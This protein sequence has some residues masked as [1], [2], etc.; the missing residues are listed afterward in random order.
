MD[1]NILTS[2]EFIVFSIAIVILMIF[3][4]LSYKHKIFI[5]IIG[6]VGVLYGLF[7]IAWRIGFSIPTN[8]SVG[9][10]F[11]IILLITEIVG[12]IQSI[13]FKVFLSTNKRA[14]PKKDTKFDE[15]PS[16]DVIIST[17]NEPLYILSRTIIST[18]K[19]DYPHDKLNV[20]VGDDGSRKD[21]EDFC[22]KVGAHYV[23]REEHAHAKAGNI[24][25]V[26]NHSSG[27]YILL[28]DADM[29][30]KKSIV[31]D[32]IYYFEDSRTGFVQSPQV[33]YNSDVYQNN[34]RVGDS[35]PNEQDFFM[36]DIL[37]KRAAYNAVL[38]VGSNAIFKRKAI[39]DIGGIPTK[40]ITEDMATGMLIQAK[41]YMSYFVNKPLALGLSVETIGDLIKQRDRWLRG[42]IQVSKKYHPLKI[43]GLNIAQRIIY[44]DG[45]LYWS[46]GL[47][48]MVY[49][50][51]PFLYLLLGITLFKA[52]G[53]DIIMAFLPYFLANIFYFRRVSKCKRNITWS[54]IYDMALAPHMAWSYL[55]EVFTNRALKFKVTPKDVKINKNY[56]NSRLAIPHIIILLVTIASLV[57]GIYKV[58]EYWDNFSV[59]MAIM[60]NLIWCLYNGLGTF[61]SLFVFADRKSTRRSIRIPA[62]ISV[63]NVIEMDDKSKNVCQEC[64]YVSDISDIGA[65]IVLSKLTNKRELNIG[66]NIYV[67]IE[68][69]GRVG[70][71][72]LR[73][74]NMEN[75]FEYGAFFSDIDFD[76]MNNINQFRFSNNL[77]YMNEFEVDKKHKSMIEIIANLFKK[78]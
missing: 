62:K 38:H 2:P 5:R 66:D 73:K 59:T 29:I 40:S 28:L 42:N 39:D 12:M 33:F 53:F 8:F 43:K 27:E 63:K 21:V 37:E 19:I 30:P 32:M 48:K 54:H 74:V 24:N 9:M 41:G 65:K 44:F 35:V 18:V 47:Q 75:Q 22:N 50:I 58:I 23:S 76:T 78:G 13:V 10:V 69:I 7:Y 70:C 68:N 34:L 45:L 26:L 60:I 52:N 77:K 57:F 3:L 46:Y 56:F 4:V 17:Y 1:P 20:Y 61:I 71:T 11:G 31:L 36:R 14:V 25:N 64:G 51:C 15:L 6:Y 72:I 16:V 67:D 49:I 55:T